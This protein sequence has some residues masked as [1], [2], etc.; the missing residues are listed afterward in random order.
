[1]RTVRTRCLGA[2]LLLPLLVACSFGSAKPVEP[3]P[4]PKSDEPVVVPTITAPLPGSSAPVTGDWRPVIGEPGRTAS[5]KGPGLFLVD[6]ETGQTEF[7][8]AP[9]GNDIRVQ[10]TPDSRYVWAGTPKGSVVADREQKLSYHWTNGERILLGI[11]DGVL[12]W[13]EIESGKQT[14][15]FRLERLDGTEIKAFT[16][17]IEY[18]SADWMIP[19]LARLTKDAFVIWGLE[20]DWQ[21]D[22]ATGEVTEADRSGGDRFTHPST[23]NRYSPDLYRNALP[24]VT[25]YGADNAPTYRVLAAYPSCG[26]SGATSSSLWRADGA[27]LALWSGEGPI[28]ADLNAFQIDSW[29]VKDG[30]YWQDPVPSPTRKDRWGALGHSNTLLTLASFGPGTTPVATGSIDWDRTN[31]S[32]DTQTPLWSANGRFLQFQAYLGGGKDYGCMTDVTG[33]PFLPPRLERAPF[34]SEIVIEV[35]TAGDCLNLRA[36]PSKEARVITCL[37]D[38]TRLLFGD[39]PLGE[40]RHPGWAMVQTEGK[41]IGWV[42]TEGQF[43]RWADR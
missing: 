22:A 24:V 10:L 11:T 32:M 13:E 16:L 28:M 39:R 27:G 40:N 3:G 18:G 20:K 7:W 19:R 5:V 31:L 42:S 25:F 8:P 37:P 30:D 14:A 21:I 36:E 15:R 9:T 35:A 38:G 2:L 34:E 43:L 41:A 23:G 29:A 4:T 33:Q 12:L 17:P 6:S 26:W 1:M